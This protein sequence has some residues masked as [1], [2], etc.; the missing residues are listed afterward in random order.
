MVKKDNEDKVIDLNRYAIGKQSTLTMKHLDTVKKF[1]AGTSKDTQALPKWAKRYKDKLTLKDDNVYLDDKRVVAD[2][3]QDDLMRELVY[4]K[5]QDVA[6]SRDAG[7]YLIKKRYLNISRRTWVDFLKK[8]RVIRQTD[9]APPKQKAGGKKLNKKGEL[10]LDL[11]FISPKDLPHKI[12]KSQN[13]IGVLVVVDRLTSLAFV[14]RT[15]KKEANVVGPIMTKAFNYF[16]KTLNMPKEKLIVYSDAGKEFGESYFKRNK[17]KHII[18]SKGSKV[19]QK[20]S[21]IERI[22]HRLKNAKRITS[23]TDGLAQATKIVN[24]SYNRVLGM[25]PNEAAEK[26]SDPEETK[27]LIIEYNKKREK[28]DTDRRKPLKIG[29]QVRVVVDQARKDKIGYKA[30]R[31]KQF[32]KEGHPVSERNKSYEHFKNRPISK[33]VYEVIEV[34]GSNPTRYKIKDWFKKTGDKPSFKWFTRDKL[35]EPTPAPDQKSEALLKSRDK[36][37]VRKKKKKSEEKEDEKMAEVTEE[38]EDE[39]PEIW[40]AIYPNR[41]AAESAGKRVYKE[42]MNMYNTYDSLPK[43]THKDLKERVNKMI[44]Y[45]D[46]QYSNVKGA[47]RSDFKTQREKFK[48]LLKKR[49]NKIDTH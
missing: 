45:W 21:H 15:G 1:L 26:Y 18:V 14:E 39:E 30:Y 19:E 48:S 5:D 49:L 33:E 13:L 2:E 17:V 46:H 43:A 38:D 47:L 44:K 31:G 35:S 11:F 32:T 24:N 29:D 23:V 42:V 22:F 41:V 8:Q 27:K 12:S 16:A 6:P 20:N 4:G 34:K 40:E 36:K 3:E 25:S 37:P 10:E 28:A 9:N 7:Y